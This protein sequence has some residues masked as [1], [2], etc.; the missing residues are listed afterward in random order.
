MDLSQFY[1]IPLETENKRPLPG[2]T[3]GGWPIDPTK[4]N[5][6]TYEEALASKKYDWGI[7]G[8]RAGNLLIVDID[9]YKMDD[10]TK[11]RVTNQWPDEFDQI[12]LVKTPSGGF[13]MYFEYKGDNLP[14][15]L[16]HVDIK[17]DV[18]KGYCKAPTIDGY[19]LVQDNDPLP[20]DKETLLDYPVFTHSSDKI[21]GRRELPPCIKL[22]QEKNGEKWDDLIK[23]YNRHKKKANYQKGGV[24]EVLDKSKYPVN[25]KTSIPPFFEEYASQDSHTRF[26]VKREGGQHLGICW[27]HEYDHDAV[28]LIGIKEG[29]FTCEQLGNGNVSKKQYGKALEMAEDEGIEFGNPVLTCEKVKEYDMCP[30]DCGRRHP[31]E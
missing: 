3:W 20:V 18:G 31:L 25:R 12:P 13:H 30:R 23:A 26:E 5:I 4:E 9:I 17:G 7:V 21:K 24:Y 14:D 19:D 10:V 27:K 8:N 15:S 2:L 6:F 11:H 28:S 22:A 29:L 16:N 1:F